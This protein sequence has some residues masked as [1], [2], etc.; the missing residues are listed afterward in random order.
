MEWAIV[1][2]MAEEWLKSRIVG[3]VKGRKH[4]FIGRFPGFL[5]PCP[6]EGGSEKVKRL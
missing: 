5:R 3:K 6:S 1:E 4:N 2:G